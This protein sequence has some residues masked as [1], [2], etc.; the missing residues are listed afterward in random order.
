VKKE[1]E[2]ER[3]GGEGGV[4]AYEPYEAVYKVFMIN[5]HSNRLTVAK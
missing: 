1:K 4:L 3:V 5:T 2:E